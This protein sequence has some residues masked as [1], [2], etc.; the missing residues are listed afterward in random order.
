MI[1]SR[2]DILQFSKELKQQFKNIS[3]ISQRT[4]VLEDSATTF[5]SK[6]FKVTLATDEEDETM[7]K[8][9]AE[10]IRNNL[11]DG[12]P[13]ENIFNCLI[14]KENNPLEK[15]I[16]RKIEK[17]PKYKIFISLFKKY[18]PKQFFKTDYETNIY[19]NIEKFGFYISWKF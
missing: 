16:L 9:F 17:K 1:L 7:D 10:S 11:V 19:D 2:I 18:F 13:T 8:E 5:I 14:L 6:Q 12:L 3:K 15:Q 4:T